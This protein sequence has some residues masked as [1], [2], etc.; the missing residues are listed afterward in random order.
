MGRRLMLIILHLTHGWA[1]GVV[2]KSTGLSPFRQ[3]L[4]YALILSIPSKRMALLSVYYIHDRRRK[5][6]PGPAPYPLLD[7]TL[8]PGLQQPSSN[9][10]LRHESPRGS[11]A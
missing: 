7:P 5:A 9:P 10:L 11:H 3:G 2:S 1:E 6:R 4:I 8:R